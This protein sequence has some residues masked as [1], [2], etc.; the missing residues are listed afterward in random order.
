MVCTNE[1]QHTEKTG[2]IVSSASRK[3]STNASRPCADL[4][5]ASGTNMSFRY[6]E[7]DLFKQDYKLEDR[8]QVYH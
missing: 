1:P 5:N 4:R 2:I 3:L 8:K 6:L 7:I